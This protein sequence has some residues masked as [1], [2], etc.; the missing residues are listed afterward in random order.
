MFEQVRVGV[1]GTSSYAD[2]THLPILKSHLFAGLTTQSAGD[3]LFIDA[4]LQDR[5][6]V[7][8]FYDG[9]SSTSDGCRHRISPKGLLGFITTTAGHFLIQGYPGEVIGWMKNLKHRRHN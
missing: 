1:I 8:G 5:P 6:A 7:P 4:I 9:P 2:V 3:R